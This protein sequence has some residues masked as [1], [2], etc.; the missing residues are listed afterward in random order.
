M[1]GKL[2]IFLD[3]SYQYFSV[4]ID[5]Y[6]QVLTNFYYQIGLD[7]NLSYGICNIYRIM[8]LNDVG[9]LI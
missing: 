4:V 1:M 9:I 3:D 6:R 8:I 7:L 2:K 5:E